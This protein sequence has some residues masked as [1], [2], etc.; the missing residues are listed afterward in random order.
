MLHRKKLDKQAVILREHAQNV[1]LFDSA[2]TPK[3]ASI[4][5]G[6]LHLKIEYLH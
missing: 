2:D 6:I 5:Y 1:L 4:A 3:F